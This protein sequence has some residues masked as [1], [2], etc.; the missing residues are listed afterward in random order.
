MV[1]NPKRDH[2]S[3]SEEEY[4]H[5]KEGKEYLSRRLDLVI[6]EQRL[7]KEKIET[8]KKALSLREANDP[9]RS[10]IEA[11]MEMNLVDLDECIRQE[12]ALKDAI[13]NL[14]A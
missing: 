4:I 7:V 9:E 1:R 14:G 2:D 11:Q 12:K 6:A 8:Q 10:L 3:F 13:A 5:P